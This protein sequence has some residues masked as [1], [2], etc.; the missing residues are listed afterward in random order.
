VQKWI[1]EHE[2]GQVVDGY[3]S[4]R[5]LRLSEATLADYGLTYRRLTAH[6]GEHYPVEQITPDA[7]QRFLM[8]IPGSRKNKLNAY[9]GLASLW[10]WMVA[11]GMTDTHVIHK[12]EKPRIIKTVIEPFEDSDIRTILADDGGR[13]TLRDR[14]MVMVLL[15]TGI[16]VSELCGLRMSDINGTSLRVLG[17]GGKERMV[18]VSMD[19]W[20]VVG[21]YLHMP[22][23][24]QT[25]YL[26]ESRWGTQMD[27]T[28][29]AHELQRIGK[30]TGIAGVHPHRFRHTFAINFLRNGGNI[31][32]LQELLGHSTLEMVKTYL[33]LAERD[34]VAAH[35]IASPVVNMG[36]GK[37]VKSLNSTTR[38]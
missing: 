12:V 4:A 37:Y 19:T 30:R 20:Q 26:F 11:Q 18:P 5:A 32:A 28:A 35:R 2:I 7:I 38:N 29:V 21:E 36:L 25:R 9:V 1:N 17:K 33:R 15:D 22:R 27:R 10:T 6:F 23:I 16:R 8:K 34:L 13:R 14:A 31:Y 24:G 3:K